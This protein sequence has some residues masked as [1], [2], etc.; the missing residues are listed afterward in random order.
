MKSRVIC[1]QTTDGLQGKLNKFL[2]TISPESIVSV[3]QS[4]TKY[5]TTIIIIYKEN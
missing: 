1:E 2:L 5:Y 4:G 3:T